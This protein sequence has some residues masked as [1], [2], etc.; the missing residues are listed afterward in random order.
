VTIAAHAVK[1]RRS[2]DRSPEGTATEPATDRVLHSLARRIGE[3][4]CAKYFGRHA[5]LDVHDHSVHVGVSSPFVAELVSRRFTDHL[6][7][8]AA[9]ALG[10]DVEARALE[11]DIRVDEAATSTRPPAPAAPAAPPPAARPAPRAARRPDRARLRLEDF[12]VGRSNQL[13]HAAAIRL[14][15]ETCP[16]A[17]SRL[18]IH[19]GCGLG[20]THLLQGVARRFEEL[21]PG[22]NVRYTTSEAFTNEFIQ[23]IRADRVDAFRRAYRHVDLL[24]VDDVH[25]LTSK[26][27]TQEELLHTFDALDLAGARVALASDEHPKAIQRLNRALVSRF[28]SGMIV[29]LDPPDHELATRL[30]VAIG[31]RRGL[32]LGEDGARLVADTIC[33]ASR[34]RPASVREIEGLVT[35]VE[36]VAR[37]LGGQ[38]TNDN[39]GVAMVRRALGMDADA[40]SSLRRRP[41]SVQL[42]ANEVCDELGVDPAELHASG[43]HRRVVLARSLTAYLSRRLTNKSYPEIARAMARPSHSTVVTA[44]RRIEQLVEDRAPVRLALEPDAPHIDLPVTELIDKLTHAIAQAAAQS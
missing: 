24:C 18:V 19:G 27:A 40:V 3:D 44:C 2:H 34:P 11:V 38:G 28:M 9:E 23:A 43:R 29:Q 26:Q 39:I 22:S 42:I 21:H 32:R 7:E 37:L 6:R 31:A 1:D 14:T 17:F 33:R 4:A 10:D 12:V 35:R 13:A 16:G 5:R 20:K 36:A 8:A 30:A 41:V 15:E 25:F